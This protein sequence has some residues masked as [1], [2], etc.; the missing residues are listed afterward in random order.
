MGS[1]SRRG[2]QIHGVLERCGV[3]SV[4]SPVISSDNALCN[5][6]G[7]V[8]RMEG[9]F[10]FFLRGGDNTGGG[11]CWSGVWRYECKMS[12][13]WGESWVVKCVM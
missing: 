9:E 6:E 10:F 13:L 1:L 11:S 5:R 4:E 8:A 7:V 3:F 2:V 12:Y